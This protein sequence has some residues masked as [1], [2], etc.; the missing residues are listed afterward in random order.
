MAA[1]DKK[2][3]PRKTAPGPVIRGLDELDEVLA[4][5]GWIW[6]GDRA[7][8]PGWVQ[9]WSY[10]RVKSYCLNGQLKRAVVRGS[11]VLYVTR[12]NL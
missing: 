11:D 7:Y 12:M 8:H 3:R 4:Y 6:F 2:R 9:A 10:G 1:A 5:G